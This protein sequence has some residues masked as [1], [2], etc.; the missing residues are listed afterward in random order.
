MPLWCV[1]SHSWRGLCAGLMTLAL[2]VCPASGQSRAQARAGIPT[3]LAPDNEACTSALPIS[4]G[5]TLGSSLNATS[6][7]RTD[8]CAPTSAD[9]WF[10]YTPN[11]GGTHTI[12]LCASDFD[13][14]LSIYSSC[15]G[16]IL[17]CNDDACGLQSVLVT[18]LI[19]GSTYSIRVASKGAASPG[20]NFRL[21]ITEPTAVRPPNDACASALT[22]SPNT[23][24]AGTT[25]GSSG[26]DASACGTADTN[27]VWYLFSPTI[28]APHRV[29]V[30]T[31]AFDAVVSVH[32]SCFAGTST[33]CNTNALI[34]GEP[35]QGNAETWITPSGGNFYI[36]VAGGR[37]SFG[38]FSVA[39]FTPRTNDL[40][41]GAIDVTAG[42][43]FSG[44]ISPAVGTEFVSNCTDS[45]YDVWHAFT[46]AQSA[47]YSVSLCSSNF[48]TVLSVLDDCNS[49]R[50]ELA[51]NDN[52]CSFRSSLSIPL[53]AARRYFIRV[54]G[55]GSPPAYGN[56]TLLADILRPS[57]DQCADATTLTA[58]TLVSASTGGATG[59]DISPC[60]TFDSAD[61]WYAFTPNA[62][63]TYEFH[64]CGS[65]IDTTLTLFSSCGGSV[66]G[67]SDDDEVF[68]G[69]G[70]KSSR[71][72]RALNAGVRYLVRIAAANAAE[73]GFNLAVNRVSPLND[74]CFNSAT[75]TLSTTSTGT[76][77]GAA[78]SGLPACS[79]PDSPDVYYDFTPAITSYYRVSTCGSQADTVL[80]VFDACPPAGN[81]LACNNNDTAACG[82]GG[83]SSVAVILPAGIKAYFRVSGATPATTG[84]HRILITRINPPNDACSST[85][86]LALD[87]PVSGLSI[88]ATGFDESPC[89]NADSLDVWF[90]FTPSV[91]GSYEFLVCPVTQGF[92][93]VLSLHTT[94]G[95]QATTC[96]TST[97]S[98]QLE[99]GGTR[100]V[101][102]LD[103]SVPVL[104]RVAG[105][106]ASTGLFSLQAS[107]ALPAN[108]AC[109]AAS[110][111]GEGSVLF[112]T[113]GAT[114]DPVFL[115]GSCALSFGIIS[116]DVWF[117]YAPIATGA[118][119]ITTCGS[120]FDTVL[121][122]YDNACPIGT[123]PVLVCNDDFPCPEDGDGRQSQVNLTFTLGHTY[124]IRVGSKL[125]QGGGGTL[126]IAR[127]GNPCPCDANADGILNSADIFFFLN[128]YFQTPSPRPPATI[129]F[130]FLNCYFARPTGCR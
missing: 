38:P 92:V 39:I 21:T 66:L 17:A 109:S 127:T 106:S 67:C 52:A 1:F 82:S 88:G 128:A 117:R 11:T 112:D 81:L 104:I 121:A 61:V 84:G 95:T 72:T 55:G 123:A 54:A 119:S 49:A 101:R 8:Q 73:G 32:T 40:C 78:A 105:A 59:T 16:P 53:T 129:I 33:V 69:S 98:C 68:C 63:A 20:G 111:I 31:T 62:N 46:P 125:P 48:D 7:G 42:V 34:P 25:A 5:V 93:P 94:C 51:C 118:G 100:V 44:S 24:T 70:S 107:Y 35:G 113:L 9:V 99:N 124:F 3:A 22:L 97:T 19:A 41:A 74:I 30:L 57:N 115:D 23:L 10:R 80:S 64:T 15:T 96:A 126:T 6:D 12:A 89:G 37:G 14:V 130:D 114:T 91:T 108:D 56:Y 77:S 26:S 120:T 90:R 103:A 122:V 28:V 4:A 27:D 13:T 79:L 116:N 29:R 60:G 58:G 76:T 75:L 18:P 86:D 102:R 45:G 87:A 85:V 83:D 47:L 50:G 43:P 71:L 2:A 65:Q 36:R 110:T